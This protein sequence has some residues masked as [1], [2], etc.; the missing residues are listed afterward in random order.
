MFR[1]SH[2]V[3]YCNWADVF[4]VFSRGSHVTTIEELERLMT[5]TSTIL[6][7]F[8]FHVTGMRSVGM[9]QL[10]YNNLRYDLL[11]IFV[12]ISP[13]STALFSLVFL[14][15]VLLPLR[16]KNITFL[17]CN[18]IEADLKKQMTAIARESWLAGSFY[19]RVSFISVFSPEKDENI[20]MLISRFS[21]FIFLCL[22]KY[23]NWKSTDNF[24]FNFLN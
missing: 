18:K 5:W 1:V 2:T 13:L 14:L 3:N 15:F 17:H 10:N 7:T 4:Q 12:P 11:E 21:F 9:H 16:K 6:I 8:Q 22:E 24:I 20:C 23:E 19:F